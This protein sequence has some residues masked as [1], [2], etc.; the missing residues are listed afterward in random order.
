MRDG[1]ASGLMTVCYVQPPYRAHPGYKIMYDKFNVVFCRLTAGSTVS[2]SRYEAQHNTERRRSRKKRAADRSRRRNGTDDDDDDV[3]WARRGGHEHEPGDGHTP[4]SRRDSWQGDERNSKG[5]GPRKEPGG[6]R[7]SLGANFGG[8]SSRERL[9]WD[10][11]RESLQG[12]AARAE[13]PGPGT[14]DRRGTIEKMKDDRAREDRRRRLIE[15]AIAVLLEGSSSSSDD[16]RL[17]D[18][19]YDKSRC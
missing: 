5:R 2:N 13:A 15:E 12:V 17:E 16:E 7:S 6:T 10:E 19:D 11:L 14:W 18:E 4:K 9:L 1:R 8:E 3:D